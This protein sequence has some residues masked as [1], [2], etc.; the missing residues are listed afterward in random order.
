MSNL[1]LSF[2]T[3]RKT[4]AAT[5]ISVLT[6]ALGIGVTTAIFSVVKAVLLNPL[7]YRQPDRLVTIAE[8]SSDR[9]DNFYVDAM[10]V[11]DW[12]R[13][14]RSFD[15][16]A[17]Y[18]DI[19]LVLM[20]DSRAQIIR[21]LRVNYNFFD[22]LGVKMK[23]GRTFLPEE[24]RPGRES[25]VVILS[26]GTWVQRFGADPEILGRVLQL[27]DSH[28]TVIGVLPADFPALI[29]GTTEL[30]PE[31]YRP[32]GYD[33]SSGCR[34]CQ[35]FRAIARL[36]PGVQVNQ[37]QAELNTITH[38]L[39]REY[40]TDYESGV[41]VKVTPVGDYVLGRVR[42]PIWA[43]FGA[44]GFV[45]L[46]ACVNVAGLLLTRGI[47]RTREMAVRAALGAGRRSLVLQ[48]LTET[49]VLS[50]AGAMGGLLI[51]LCAT[52]ALVSFL[53][54][55]IPRLNEIHTDS[56]ALL[57][58]VGVCLFTTVMCGLAPAWFATRIDLNEVLKAS[59]KG[60]AGSRP[61]RLHTSLVVTELA[62][63][64]VLVMGAGVMERSFAHLMKVNPGYEPHN[65]LTLTTHVWGDRYWNHPGKEP[66]YYRQALARVRATPG[67]DGAAW[68]SILPLDYSVRERLHIEGPVYTEAEAPLVD[69]YSVSR[70]YFSVMRIPLKRGRVFAE[71]DGAASPRVAL[72]SESCA[73]TEFPGG[74][75]IGKHIQLGERNTTKQWATIVGIVGDIRQY[76]LDRPSNMEVYVSQEQDLIIDYYRLVART[77]FDP[78]LLEGPVRSAFMEVDSTLPVYHVKSLEDYL[79]GSLA[80]REVTLVL[81][82]L[83]GMLAL[84][85]GALGIYGVISYAV[86]LRTHEV[87]V[88]IALGAQRRG[89]LRLVLSQGLVLTAMGLAIGLLL[90][91]VLN[92]FLASLL[93]EI[94]P[95][96]LTTSAVVTVVLT[97]VALGA[98]Y[99]P[100]R[101]AAS[102]DPIVAL[103]DE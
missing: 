17:L 47:A 65:V 83:F 22:T 31:M 90:S 13:R 38:T 11:Q 32:A 66:D 39:A 25:A 84:A 33:F 74:D 98:S 1:L 103:R 102:V 19:A 79:A 91:S 69:S 95:M 88:R 41:G 14:S 94:R 85:L 67:V 28:S 12:R 3:L 60:T 23:L 16:I 99:V 8:N 63:A 43:V 40:S 4:P 62:L 75:P 70:D 15:N 46:I 20:E 82:S 68:T 27:S 57:F 64:F 18:E 51:A 50:V 42:T 61:H 71:Q 96:D 58:S 52:R 29:H 5:A 2:R 36:S 53:P 30:L 55:Q 97:F 10:T 77:T 78:R 45:L 76:G 24:D 73:R 80:A 35:D 56:T 87:G 101:R 59:R 37:A 89:I 100:A 21:G 7:A 49:L 9:P 92:R 54:T 86:A 44:A 72:I 34:R 26:Y 93:F 48:L 81:L 6:L